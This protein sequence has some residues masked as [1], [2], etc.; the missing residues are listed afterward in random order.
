MDFLKKIGSWADELTKIGISIVA[1]ELYL[2][3]YSKVQTFHFG[4][5]YQ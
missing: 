3:Y 4:Q 2:K 5:K 1:L